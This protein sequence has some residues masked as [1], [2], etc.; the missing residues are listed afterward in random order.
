VNGRP[1]DPEL[2]AQEAAAMREQVA[3]DLFSN[4]TPA[5]F[6]TTSLPALALA[7]AA[8]RSGPRMGEHVSLELRKALFEHGTDISDPAVL[9]DLARRFGVMVMDSD[10]RALVEEFAEGRRR[11]VKGS[12]HVFTD[13]TDVFCPFL[14]IRKTDDG[15]VIGTR[16][17]ALL[18]L[19]VSA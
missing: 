10:R 19:A 8:Y 5:H 2:V 6:P 1:L 13:D 7:H 3:P 18:D 14:D 9:D 12:P 11:G 16:P 4:F 15:L 17:E